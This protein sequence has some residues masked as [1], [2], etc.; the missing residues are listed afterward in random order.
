M[1]GLLIVMCLLKV[2]NGS[3]DPSCLIQYTSSPAGLDFVH[4]STKTLVCKLLWLMSSRIPSQVMCSVKH[5]NLLHFPLSSH[6]ALSTVLPLSYCTKTHKYSNT[7]HLLCI[8][9]SP[10]HD[11]NM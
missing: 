4:G 5:P 10:S 3:V 9:R 8:T 2:S 6:S 7:Y 11:S 1:G